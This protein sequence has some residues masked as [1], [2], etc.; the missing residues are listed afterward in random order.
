MAL[1]A[2][3]S[4]LRIERIVRSSVAAVTVLLICC[5]Y[6]LRVR[7]LTRAGRGAAVPLPTRIAC[8]TGSET[9]DVRNRP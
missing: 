8:I 2:V 1:T 7:R 5:D 3:S 6:G 9:K 4:R